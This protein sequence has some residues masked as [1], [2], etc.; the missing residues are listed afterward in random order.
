MR[1]FVSACLV[2]FILVI[3]SCYRVPITNRYQFRVLPDQMLLSLSFSS[4]QDFITKNPPLTEVHPDAARVKAVGS[5]MS[6]VVNHFLASKGYKKVRKSFQWSFEVVNNPQVNAWCLP[7]GKIVFYTGIMPVCQNEAGIAVV[8]GHEMAHAVARHGNER[9]SQYLILQLGIASLEVAMKE[10]PEETR[11]LFLALFGVGGALGTLAYS[12][13]HE[14]EADKIG[15]VFM[16]LAG[17]D[18]AEAIAFWERM[19]QH[20]RGHSIPQFLSTHPTSANRIKAMKEFL[21]KAQRYYR[22]S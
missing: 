19:Q 15:M 4:Y 2:L 10:K 17:Y 6:R 3:E 13:K 12:R 7:G 9:L 16:A 14:Y 8:M 21:P 1:L 5:R 20:S 22:P 18:P 11:E